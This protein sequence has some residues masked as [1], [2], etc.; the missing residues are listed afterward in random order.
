MGSHIDLSMYQRIG[1]CILGSAAGILH[2][3]GLPVPARTA[4]RYHGKY[5]DPT[6]CDALLVTLGN[7]KPNRTNKECGPLDRVITWE[8]R[9]FR[10]VC[11][12]EPD[13]CKDSDDLDLTGCG[14]AWLCPG[15]E[16]PE[17]QVPGGCGVL[18]PWVEHALLMADRHALE[19]LLA[20]QI[21][22]C[23]NEIDFSDCGDPCNFRCSEV[24]WIGS[25]RKTGG[26][27]AGTVLTFETDTIGTS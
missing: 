17:D 7:S 18:D 16:W 20:E 3:H 5:G 23:L 1:C 21:K 22:C 10:D 25:A 4:L 14:A 27:C 6:C 19:A 13:K 8:V 12:V 11:Q 26:G 24:R 15:E 9:I 2:A